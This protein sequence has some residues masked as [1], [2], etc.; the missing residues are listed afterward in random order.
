MGRPVAGEPHR[1]LY[2]GLLTENC[3]AGHTQVFSELRGWVSLESVT[4]RDRVW[5]GEQF[6][7][8]SG[9][10]SKGMHAVLSCHGCICTPDHHILSTKG[11][12]QAEIAC[13]MA[14]AELQMFHHETESL[15]VDRPFGSA[16]RP[17]DRDKPVGFRRK[18]ELLACEVR[19]R[20][21]DGEGGVRA[22]K[23]ESPNV[24][25]RVPILQEVAGAA[26]AHPRNESASGICCVAV[27]A[28]PLPTPHSPSMEELR[29][30]RDRCL[31]SV[32]RGLSKFL[33]GCSGRVLPGLGVGPNRQRSG[34]L[35]R[36]CS[37]G[38]PIG[39]FPKSEEQCSEKVGSPR[40]FLGF[41]PSS[42]S[43]EK[44]ALLSG[45]H[46]GV[47]LGEDTVN[48]SHSCECRPHEEGTCEVFDLVDCG[49]NHRFAIRAGEGFP[50]LIAHNCTQATAREILV[51]GLLKM[52]KAGLRVVLHVHDEV[53]VEVKE[54]QVQDAKR[55]IEEIMS[56]APDWMPGLPLACEA[57]IADRYGK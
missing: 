25:P 36:E 12:V 43:E 28:G 46:D 20:E 42:W 41:G 29:R 32:E 44:H 31:R 23:R 22:E 56:T 4:L 18:E 27:D 26:L 2:G 24:W 53:V 57:K 54:D 11:W 8:H 5:D 50:V 1:K 13:R 15:A 34:V 38:P 39:E 17:S 47:E 37:L 51:D 14:C 40:E 9:L 48:A 7:T 19:L 30:S 49:P 33:G 35:S 16:V 6:V 10:V 52:Q 21:G 45:E 55:Q 3:L